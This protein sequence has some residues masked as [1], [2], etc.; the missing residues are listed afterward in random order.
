MVD[1]LNTQTETETDTDSDRETG[2]ERL[3][4]RETDRHADTD[5]LIRTSRFQRQ[6]QTI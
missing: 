1:T 6:T 4:L 5:N 2:L 3:D